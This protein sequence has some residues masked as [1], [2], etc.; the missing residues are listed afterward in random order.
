MKNLIIINKVNGGL[1]SARN[2][3][4][5]VARG[6]YIG[7]V[8]SDD[9]IETTMFE[10][11]YTKSKKE[12][13]DLSA[14]GEDLTQKAR[15][16]KLDEVIGRD[17]EIDRVVQIL[18]RRTKNNAVL[19]GEPGVGKTAVV[20]GLAQR[21]VRGDVPENLKNKQTP[22]RVTIKT[23]NE[24]NLISLLFISILSI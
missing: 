11:L 24:V 22:R 8:D 2:A 17:K 23:L 6:E 21:I 16:G 12:E 20:E 5:K 10:K 19:I 7:F 14:L 13:L 4:M 3:G 15:E 1:S 18:C 9:F